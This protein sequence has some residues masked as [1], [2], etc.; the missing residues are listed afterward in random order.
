MACD[1]RHVLAGNHH[2]FV[3]E[4][5]QLERMPEHAQ[6][7]EIADVIGHNIEQVFGYAKLMEYR[8]SPGT[9]RGVYVGGFRVI[10]PNQ[11]V[12]LARAIP[13]PSHRPIPT[14]ESTS[15]HGP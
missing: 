8:K 6:C 3:K 9:D 4:L 14:T 7:D 13:F 12:G 11:L 2:V 15:G 1:D 10:G 5:C